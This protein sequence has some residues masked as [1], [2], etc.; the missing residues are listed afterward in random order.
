VESE[1]PPR[2][3]EESTPADHLAAVRGDIR[4]LD[5]ETM[6]S[7]TERLVQDLETAY[8]ELR[9]ADEEVRAQQDQIAQLLEGQHLVR[10]QHERMTA[11]LP[12]PVVL[13]DRDGIIRSVNASAATLL[14]M[15]VGRVV[16][17][18]VLSVFATED[19]IDVRRLLGR[20]ADDGTAFR[21]VVTVHGRDD[22]WT[23]A[24]LFVSHLPGPDP[25]LSWM[26]LV[27][28]ATEKSAGVGGAALPQALTQMALLPTVVSETQEVLTR[29]AHICQAG[30]GPGTEVSVS[31]GPPDSPIAVASTS[32][33]AQAFDGA[34][35]RT[36][37]GPYVTA[38]TEQHTVEA[39]DVLHD[40]RWPHLNERRASSVRSA[41]SVP[42]VVGDDLVGCLNVYGPGPTQQP[43][44]REDV[45]LMAATLAAVLFELGLKRELEE[46]AVGLEHA[47]E[48]RA[49]IDQ[50]KGIV[51]ADR[52]VD[53]KAAFEHLVHLSSTRH[54][55]LREVAQEI[56][57]WASGP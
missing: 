28:A 55:K 1:Q 27:G 37:E 3:G 26:L 5:P 12:V 35:L 48:S 44:H 52:R 7:S 53:A 40:R 29:A 49:V 31:L 8:E 21:R 45:E 25:E 51:M 14:R 9:V 16:G 57:D 33:D 50:A 47:L 38:F 56:V 24:E 23:S 22:H 2:A 39:Q 15:G 17:K 18:P 34:Q 20:L 6:D 46:L 43:R 10:W 36:G 30:L 19:R 13:T 41:V 11:A 54:L 4:A 42:L 32:Q